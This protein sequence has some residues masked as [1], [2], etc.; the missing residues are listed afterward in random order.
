MWIV[1]SDTSSAAKQSGKG[2]T[3][4]SRLLKAPA[5][6]SN[7]RVR[8]TVPSHSESG[9]GSSDWASL[10]C[11]LKTRVGRQGLVWFYLGTLCIV[12]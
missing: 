11:L 7:S 8:R 12:Q 4:A 9:I 3:R 2:S 10:G 6:L 1:V 5:R